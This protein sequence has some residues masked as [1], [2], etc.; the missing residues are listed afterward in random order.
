LKGSHGAR[1]GISAAGPPCLMLL[2]WLVRSLLVRLVTL[3]AATKDAVPGVIVG[4][5]I[6]NLALAGREIPEV[7]G[8]QM[9][10]ACRL[11]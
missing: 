8:R 11:A 9:P 10:L 1:N 3:Q 5:W 6:L 4:D 2:N 7:A